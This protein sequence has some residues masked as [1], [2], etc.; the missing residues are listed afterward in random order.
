MTPHPVLFL[1]H[2]PPLQN[3]PSLPSTAH[4]PGAAVS[5]IGGDSCDDS[6]D[7]DL[8]VVPTVLTGH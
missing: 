2:P 8:H 6:H 4:S 5:P 1:L 3:N 7:S